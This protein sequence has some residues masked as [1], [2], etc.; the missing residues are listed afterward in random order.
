MFW[1]RCIEG[2]VPF[3]CALDRVHRAYLFS[4][5]VLR[6]GYITTTNLGGKYLDSSMVISLVAL[7]LSAFSFA[8]TIYEKLF[9]RPRLKV[10]AQFSF[11]AN[12]DF[13]SATMLR[14]NA[15]NL[16]P[17]K[18]IICGIVAHRLYFLGRVTKKNKYAS[19]IPDHTNRFNKPFPLEVEQNNS[20]DHYLEVD[21]NII[22]NGD[23]NRIGLLDSLGRIHWVSRKNL[24]NLIEEYHTSILPNLS[25]MG[26]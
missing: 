25:N 17:G 18:A 21:S 7:V 11:I 23:F 2:Y 4:G 16:G 24:R 15:L 9:L 10:S 3:Q 8:W 22:A 19:I 5:A 26:R 20:G 14:L 12:Q 6:R 1:P 13:Q